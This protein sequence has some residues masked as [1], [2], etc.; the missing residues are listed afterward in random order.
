M[1]TQ[2]SAT[3]SVEMKV[4]QEDIPIQHYLRQPQRLVHALVDPTRVETLGTNHFRLKLRPLQFMHL[5]IQPTVDMQVQA[6]ADGTVYLRST[7]SE[8][9]GVEY[10][11]QRFSLDLDGKLTSRNVGNNAAFLQGQANLKVNVEL[12]PALQF[13]PQPFLESAGNSLLR[14]VLM[15]IKQRLLNHLLSDYRTWVHHQTDATE[16]SGSAAFSTR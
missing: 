8:V 10:I 15:T 3:Q 1:V 12:P 5:K 16:Q 9:R 7:G 2:F 13:T 4:P 11:N 14:G 6:D